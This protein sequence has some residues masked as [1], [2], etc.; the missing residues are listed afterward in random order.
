MFLISALKAS[1]DLSETEQKDGIQFAEQNLKGDVVTMA[2]MKFDNFA[3]PI[4]LK[5]SSP[6]GDQDTDLLDNIVDIPNVMPHH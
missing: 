3:E 4:S 6:I 5:N 2:H 1:P